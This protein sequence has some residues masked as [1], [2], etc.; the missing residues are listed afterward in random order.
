MEYIR[1]ATGV[2][3]FLTMAVALGALL[4][5]DDEEKPTVELDPRSSDFMK[6]KIGETRIDP[7]SGFSQAIVLMSRVASGQRKSAN[8]EIV[9]LRGPDVKYGQGGTSA[10]LGNFLR[11]KLAP[12]PG[13]AIDIV[14]GENVVGQP[15]TPIGAVTS[16]FVPLAAQE[17]LD[18][19]RSQGIPKGTAVTMLALLGMGASTYGPKTEFAKADEAKRIDL[20]GK[21][22]TIQSLRSSGVPFTEA[23]RLLIKNWEENRGPAREMKKGVLVYKEGLANRLR[24][25]RKAY[26]E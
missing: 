24:E 4:G 23:R 7:M 21:E 17:L 15:E 10:V 19:M 25:L 20:I 18:T 9:D 22:E 2:G 11:S 3:S 26:A 12:I 1:H 16:L 5:G 13:T 8:G 14:S 6:L